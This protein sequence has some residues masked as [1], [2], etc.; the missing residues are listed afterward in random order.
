MRPNSLPHQTKRV[1]QQAA[2]FEVGQEAGDWPIDAP[3]VFEVFGH[4]RVLIPGRV[5]RVVAV[6]DLDEAD[7]ALAEAAGQ[8]A[9][10][11]EVVGRLFAD[12]VEGEGFR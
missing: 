5:G 6:G 7:S 11:A 8:Q 12:A 4:V 1:V 3:G 9:L 2:S 10:A